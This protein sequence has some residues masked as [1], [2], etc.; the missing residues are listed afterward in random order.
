M[1]KSKAVIL[2]KTLF[3]EHFVQ[4]INWQFTPQWKKSIF[5]FLLNFSRNMPRYAVLLRVKCVFN[6]NRQQHWHRVQPKQLDH[7]LQTVQYWRGQYIFYCIYDT[8]YTLYIICTKCL[9]SKFLTIDGMLH[10]YLCYITLLCIYTRVS[11]NASTTPPTSSL[12]SLKQAMSFHMNNNQQYIHS[13]SFGN[14]VQV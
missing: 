8:L 4:Q 14:K 5:F 7:N 3:R 11:V 12:K 13:K 6:L 2:I 10:L 9:Y 1:K